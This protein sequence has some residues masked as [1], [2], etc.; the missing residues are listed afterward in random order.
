VAAAAA[1]RQRARMKAILFD[2][3]NRF[4]SMFCKP[5]FIYTLHSDSFAIDHLYDYLVYLLHGWAGDTNIDSME[6]FSIHINR[7]KTVPTVFQITICFT[8]I[9]FVPFSM[10][11]LFY[12]RKLPFRP[13]PSLGENDPVCADT[14]CGW[15][16]LGT[17][18]RA[19][20]RAQARI[21]CFS[22]KNPGGNREPPPPPPPLPPP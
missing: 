14:S 18:A 19:V 11:L 22:P 10:K 1:V 20:A 9:S 6:I 12:F 5:L 4:K 8:K 16:E 17:V 2:A 7:C 21:Q 15:E 13:A 3:L